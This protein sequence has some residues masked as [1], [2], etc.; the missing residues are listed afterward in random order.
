[1]LNLE[2]GTSQPVVAADQVDG[3]LGE[4]SKRFGLKT[5]S[6]LTVQEEQNYTNFVIL[7]DYTNSLFETWDAQRLSLGR[8]GSGAKFLG[9]ELVRLSQALAVIVESVQETYDAMD[10]VFFG[11]EER[12]VTLLRFDDGESITVAELLTWIEHFAGI[13][14][15]QLIEESGKDGVGAVRETLNRI[16]GLLAQVA[17]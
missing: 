12:Q 14:A 17:S 16:N 3:L 7:V 13:E 10:S 9:T 2:P 4:L 8:G 1:L 5:E 15:P 11:P 6:V